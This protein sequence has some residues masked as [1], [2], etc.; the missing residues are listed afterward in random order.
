MNPETGAA[1]SF[2]LF[3]SD[4][5]TLSQT[6]LDF[7]G[8]GVLENYVHDATDDGGTNQASGYIDFVD[9]FDS[10]GGVTSFSF[11]QVGNGVGP[12]GSFA[13][14]GQ[15]IPEP[16]SAVILAVL[17]IAASMRRRRKAMVNRG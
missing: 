14:F 6:A 2:A 15:A 12:T 4:T 17:P 5:Q 10:F 9:N 11:D 13:V 3:A 16:S 8:D 7:N 1:D